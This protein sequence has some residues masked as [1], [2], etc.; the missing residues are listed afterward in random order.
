M[1]AVATAPRA[2]RAADRAAPRPAMLALA[3][4]EAVR[5]LRHPVGIVASLI[6]L[7]PYVYG[8]VS[9]R[10]NRF[11]VLQQHALTVQ[12]LSYLLLGA[13]ALVVANLAALRPDRHHTG[14]LYDVLVLPA[15]WRTGALLLAVLGL[16]GA[17]AAVTGVCV[18]VPAT[19]AGAAG[20]AS[21]AELATAP[22]AVVLL[23]AAGV[24]LARLVR[25]AVVAPLAAVM[26]AVS[27]YVGVASGP[28]GD[29]WRLLMPVYPELSTVALP[30]ELAD[31]PAARHLAYLAGL[32]L[33]VAILAVR[34]AGGGGRWLRAVAVV[35]ALLCAVGAATQFV[36]DTSVRRA[37]TA[38]VADPA[39]WQACR[40]LGT[41]TYCMF[42][43]FT[44]WLRSV[45]E[46]LRGVRRPV[47][48]NLIAGPPLAVRQRVWGLGVSG[49]NGSSSSADEDRA[50]AAQWAGRNV[51]AGTPEA[52][53]IGT[54]WGDGESE[55]AFAAA[56]GYRLITGH[57]WT[58]DQIL[59]G[60]RGALLVWL[61]GQATP[62]TADGLRR[63][64]ESSWNALAMQ[65][66]DLLA[67]VS[68]PDRDAAAGLALLRRPAAEVAPLV[69]Q[70]WRELV[71]AGTDADRFGALVGV[72]L[73]PPPP[74]EE[75]TRCD[76]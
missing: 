17:A 45:D 26:L 25:S 29:S 27:V 22:V 23:G 49:S 63:L 38:V 50:R 64:D 70:H 73:Q 5:M 41:V 53:S 14:P 44:P 67:G 18:G 3:R 9:G 54:R 71:A 76:G 58:G 36:P 13:A 21:W 16:G 2:D 12:L 62:R 8:W 24:L 1:S 57:A 55:A 30:A 66:P 28:A 68:V 11:P 72:P 56:V 47:P 31:R 51:A 65:D 42:S 74:A 6:L 20:R 40:P 4:V 52:I 7:L 46:V 60:A 35:A 43:D 39:A 15:A 10:A 19:F 33:L 69:A 32:V 37:R 48:G 75:R 34:R 61:V 59:C